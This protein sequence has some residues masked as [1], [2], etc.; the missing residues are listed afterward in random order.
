MNTEDYINDVVV[1]AKNT[2]PILGTLKT[3]YYLS[4]FGF[5]FHNRT[6]LISWH[7]LLN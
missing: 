6:F 5:L 1:Q 7:L 3:L 2:N 4:L